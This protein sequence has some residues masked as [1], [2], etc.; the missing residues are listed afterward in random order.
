M[1]LVVVSVVIPHHSS[2]RWVETVLFWR[3]DSLTVQRRKEFSYSFE[4]R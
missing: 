1:I 4:S 2:V 3:F